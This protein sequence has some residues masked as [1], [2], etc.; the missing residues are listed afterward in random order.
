MFYIYMIR[1]QYNNL[2]IGIT[3]NPTRRLYEHNT[4]RGSNFTKVR[5]IF[6]IVFLEKHTTL[7]KARSREIQI[8][9]WTRKKKYFL[10]TKYSIGLKTIY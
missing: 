10:I 8:K 3:D 6:E 4:H 9:K 2:Y 7:S 1:N 5:N